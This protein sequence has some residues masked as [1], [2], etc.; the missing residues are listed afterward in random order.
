MVSQNGASRLKVGRTL[1][2]RWPSVADAKSGNQ[3][4]NPMP[5]RAQEKAEPKGRLTV[6]CSP[7]NMEG[8]IIYSGPPEATFNEA[9]VYKALAEKGVV[10]GTEKAAIDDLVLK[11]RTATEPLRLNVVVARGVTPRSSRDALLEFLI[12]EGGEQHTRQDG[13]TDFRDV[14]KYKIV[15]KDQPLARLHPAVEGEAGRN[16][17]G[18]PVPVPP[19]RQASWSPGENIQAVSQPDGLVEYRALVDGIFRRKDATFVVA[20]ELVIDGNAGLETG[21][22]KCPLSILVHGN[23]ERGTE[24]VAGRDLKVDGFVE[25]GVLRVAGK[26]AVAGG[27]NAAGKGTILCG[28]DLQADFI[29]TSHI[30]C[31]GNIAVKRFCLASTIVAHGTISLEQSE[32]AIVGGEI[33]HY[34]NISLGRI[35][36]ENQIRTVFH[37]GIHYHNQHVYRTLHEE[38]QRIEKEFH[39]LAEYLRQM[40]ERLARVGAKSMSEDTRAEARDR[41]QKYHRLQSLIEKKKAALETIFR[42]R[43]N[44]EP[45]RIT[46]RDV[47]LPGTEFHHNG[48]IE[49]VNGPL[50]KVIVTFYPE[51]QEPTYS[52]IP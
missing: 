19:P 37:P 49:K 52:Q 50:H 40:K 29:E 5:D 23:V 48:H 11:V 7:D 45:V 18:A 20:T 3:P 13:G 22:L 41:V 4:R 51:G 38:L 39:V 17:L 12:E 47:L 27:I 16:V 33:V 36:N 34:G 25:T 14:Q 46:V 24:I 1:L 30:I 2:D 35:G 28:G 10:F 9:G 26:L 31:D 42:T 44:P 32:A 43:K 8:T 15:K 21:N 6:I